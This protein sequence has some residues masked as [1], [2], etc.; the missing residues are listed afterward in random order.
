[1]ED[2]AKAVTEAGIHPDVDDRVVAGVTHRQPVTSKVDQIDVVVV[3][4]VRVEITQ[5]DEQV[6]RQPTHCECEHASD[7]HL[8]HLQ[9]E[10]GKD[11]RTKK[12]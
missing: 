10:G 3:P 1:M 7:H 2:V 8:H 4:H 6:E 12:T 11:I 5:K 9:Q